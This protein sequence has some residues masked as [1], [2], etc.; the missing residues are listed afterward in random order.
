M[1]CRQQCRTQGALLRLRLPPRAT[2][3]LGLRPSLIPNPGC[4]LP[5][6]RPCWH[7]IAL[8]DVS[9]PRPHDAT[10][11]ARRQRLRALDGAAL[12]RHLTGVP[13]RHQLPVLTAVKSP[14]EDEPAGRLA[15]GIARAGWNY[16]S[17]HIGDQDYRI[18]R[19]GAS[20]PAVLIANDDSSMTADH[21][22]RPTQGLPHVQLRSSTTNFFAVILIIYQILI[23]IA[24]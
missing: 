7:M 11:V 4:C 12:V 9:L 18:E 6:R 22:H 17:F 10:R 5:G 21:S 20:A 8:G 3:R 23:A 16:P 14:K 1:A 13:S 15:H 19:P 24:Q 2:A